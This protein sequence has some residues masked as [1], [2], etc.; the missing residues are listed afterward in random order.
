VNSTRA[1]VIKNLEASIEKLKKRFISY[2]IG[3]TWDF[4]DKML[5]DYEGARLA[6]EQAIKLTPIRW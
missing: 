1:Q 6:W 4:I 5:T 3:F 2:E